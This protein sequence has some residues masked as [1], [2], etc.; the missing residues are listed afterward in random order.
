M[1][2]QDDYHVILARN[3]TKFLFPFLCLRFATI[4]C[5]AQRVGLFYCDVLCLNFSASHIFLRIRILLH[6]VESEILLELTSSST[7]NQ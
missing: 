4:L 3:P 6:S 2:T 5:P 1:S 7:R